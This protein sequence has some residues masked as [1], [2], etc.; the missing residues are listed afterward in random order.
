MIEEEEEV[1]KHDIWLTLPLLP[2]I[3]SDS[4]LMLLPKDLYCMDVL[5]ESIS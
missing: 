2:R 5:H 4:A 1:D 3:F